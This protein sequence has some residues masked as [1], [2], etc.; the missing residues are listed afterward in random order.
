MVGPCRLEARDSSGK[1]LAEL[2]LHNSIDNQASPDL[3][4]QPARGCAL[5]RA[6]G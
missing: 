2:Q 3:G 5:R 6:R 4:L 1:V